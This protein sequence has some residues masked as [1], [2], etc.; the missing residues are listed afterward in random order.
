MTEETPKMGYVFPSQDAP[1]W[2]NEFKALMLQKDASDFAAREDRNF[3][4]Y[5]AAVFSW[6]ANEGVLS[7]DAPIFGLQPQTGGL[8]FIEPASINLAQ[9][10]FAYFDVVRGRSVG[11]EITMSVGK[12]LPANDDTYAL[13]VRINDDLFFRNGL[14]LGAGEAHKALGM[15]QELGRFTGQSLYA[16]DAGLAVGTPVYISG[17]DAVAAADATDNTKMPC[18][19]VVA[20]KPTD[21]TC[22]LQ[23]FGEI[24]DAG[25]VAGTWYY[26]DTTAGDITDTPP[27]VSG[28][29]VQFFG[30]ARSATKLTLL[31]GAPTEVP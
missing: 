21:T 10:E 31:L 26:I 14:M 16:C 1:A 6:N 5:S 27:A 23:T 17:A 12:I 22:Y 18:V 9:T 7:W 4:F 30:V 2:F 3:F 8:W 20:F 29:I 11:Q 24:T 19:G 15:S 13:L 28:N 25:L